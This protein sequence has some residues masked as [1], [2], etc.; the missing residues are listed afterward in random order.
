MC[1]TLDPLVG[2]MI[3]TV[4]ILCIPFIVALLIFLTDMV[5]R[6]GTKNGNPN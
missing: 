5:R 2:F 3:M 4:P 1:N 6:S